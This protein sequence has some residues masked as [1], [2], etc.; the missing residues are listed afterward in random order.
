MQQGQ[1]FSSPCFAPYGTSNLCFVVL[2]VYHFSFQSK[3]NVDEEGNVQFQLEELAP[4]TEKALCSL[5]MRLT[6]MDGMVDQLTHH[7]FIYA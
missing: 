1:S 4:G 7:L 6:D 2:F 5:L 3:S